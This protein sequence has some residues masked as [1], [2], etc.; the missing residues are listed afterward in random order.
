MTIDVST[1]NHEIIY[2]YKVVPRTQSNSQ[3]D[4]SYGIAL[5]GELLRCEAPVLT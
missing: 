2:K 4:L 5:A 3:E 1:Q